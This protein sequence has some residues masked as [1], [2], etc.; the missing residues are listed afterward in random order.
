MAKRQ[1]LTLEEV[2]DDVL[3]DDEDY[4]PDEPM[5]EGSDD[6]FS[7]LEMDE[8]NYDDLCDPM[9]L[10]SPSGSAALPNSPTHSG[11]PGHSTPS[12][13]VSPSPQL[14]PNGTSPSSSGNSLDFEY[15]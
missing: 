14:S 12:S 1:H 2:L 9:D 6:E 4:D 13:P 5:M 3:S 11:I 7:D 8:R 15:R 10:G